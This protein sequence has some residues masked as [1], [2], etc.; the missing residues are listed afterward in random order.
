M[1]APTWLP[2]AGDLWIAIALPYA[3]WGLL[4]PPKDKNRGR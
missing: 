3:L 2:V 4:S 1:T